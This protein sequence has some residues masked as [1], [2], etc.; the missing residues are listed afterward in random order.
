MT[1]S[2][3]S[4]TTHSASSTALSPEADFTRPAAD[5]P[6]LA[7]DALP[8][9]APPCPTPVVESP[10]STRRRLLLRGLVASAAGV[11]LA[12]VLAALVSRDDDAGFDETY[13]GRRIVGGRDDNRRPGDDASGAWHVT[14][15]GRPLHLMRRVDGS[16]MTMIDHYQSYPTPLAA[17]R[18][19]V[20][21]LGTARLGVWHSSGA[22]MGDSGTPSGGRGTQ[23]G[24]Q[25]GVH[26]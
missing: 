6:T 24:H 23:G 13:R 1:G 4:A 9:T 21:E 3:N 25:H 26:A 14:V 7:V 17:A 18:A 2:V 20:D 16:W 12:P 8:P 19:A 22:H 5:A 11:T 10:K 15:D